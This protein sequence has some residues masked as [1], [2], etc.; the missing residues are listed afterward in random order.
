VPDGEGS[1]RFLALLLLGLLCAA[2]PAHAGEEVV[3]TAHYRL[4]YEGPREEAEAY[5]RVLEAAWPGYAAHLGATPPLA[6]GE[7]LA[8]RFLATRE[9]WEGAIRDDGTEAPASAGGYYW[10]A[11]RTAYLYRQPTEYFSRVLLVH[12]AAHQ[13]H[14]LARTGNRN[15]VAGWYT[16]GVAEHLSW[17]RW[18][19]SRLELAVVPGV[20]LKDY[21]A[22]AL[23]ETSAPGFDLEA[24]VAGDRAPSRALAWALYGFL[25]T[26]DGGK[27]LRGFA[28]LA[29][30]LDAGGRPG[31]LFRRAF[32]R[33][34]A[35]LPRLRAWLAEHQAPWAQV[36]NEWEQV[37]EGRFRGHAGVVTA[38]RI[39]APAARLAAR[40]LLPASG[41][42]RG[43]LLLHHQ[44]PA[45]FTVA[46][47]GA[48][49]ALRVDRRQGRGWTRLLHIGVPL[50]SGTG[51]LRLEARRRGAEV[52]L[53]V[54]GR[55]LGRFRLPGA[56]LGLA[57]EDGDL[58]FE[59]V[60]WDPGG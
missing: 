8:V 25:A 55:L 44:G 18:D 26:G 13:F 52:E 14:Y 45:D 50:D 36:F 57:A 6:A 10:P 59:D 33:P 22:A 21:P 5:A 42:G 51:G 9:A 37:G 38:C 4:R 47:V 17:H 28:T 53:A 29:R 41:R 16:E 2:R 30:K 15:P 23:E 12:E 43:G 58:A 54:D 3:E 31:P 35:L 34:Q 20:T 40:L 32:G 19:G 27:P 1:R 46:L 60:A 7:K 24:I 56:T 49:G 39:K 48:D 11:S